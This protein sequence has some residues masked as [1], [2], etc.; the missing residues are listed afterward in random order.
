M[1]VVDGFK[2]SPRDYQKRAVEAILRNKNGIIVSPTGSGKGSI[3]V[4]AAT[5]VGK[6]TLVIV[7]RGELVRQQ[8]QR[9]LDVLE[10]IDKIDI[11]TIDGRGKTIKDITIATWQSLMSENIKRDVM[12]YGFDLLIIDEAH[13]AAG[14]VLNKFIEEHDAEYKIGLTATYLFSRYEKKLKV[15]KVLGKKIFEINIESLYSKGFL[16]R[17]T[18]IFQNTSATIGVE[19]GVGLYLKNKIERSVKYR[20]FLVNKAFKNPI[21]ASLLKSKNKHQ[22]AKYPTDEDVSLLAHIA[23]S[24]HS[25]EKLDDKQ[26]I[27]LAKK[28]IEENPERRAKILSDLKKFLNVKDRAMLLT[29]TKSFGDYLAKELSKE[30]GNIIRIKAGEKGAIS[31]LGNLDSYIAVG[32]VSLLSDGF[33][34]P[35]LEKIALC[36]PSY[37]PFV[38]ATKLVQITGRVVR[39]F[40]GK[41]PVVLVFDDTTVGFINLKKQRAYADLKRE[42]N[43]VIYMDL[44]HFV[45]KRMKDVINI[46]SNVKI[47]HIDIKKIL[48]IK[49]VGGTKEIA[50]KIQSYQNAIDKGYNP[51]KLNKKVFYVSEDET[52]Y[53]YEIK[54]KKAELVAKLDDALFLYGGFQNEEAWAYVDNDGFSHLFLKDAKGEYYDVTKTHGVK[55]KSVMAFDDKWTYTPYYGGTP[56]EVKLQTIPKEKKKKIVTFFND[57]KVSGRRSWKYSTLDPSVTDDKE[58]MRTVLVRKGYT[59]RMLDLFE[60]DI[61]TKKD[62]EVDVTR[63]LDAIDAVSFNEDFWGYKDTNNR[64]HLFREK[65]GERFIDMVEINKTKDFDKIRECATR[66]TPKEGAEEIIAFKNGEYGYKIDG[67]F[68]FFDAEDKKVL[69]ITKL[70]TKFIVKDRNDDKTEIVFADRYED[71]SIIV[72]KSWLLAHIQKK[73]TLFPEFT[74]YDENETSVGMKKEEELEDMLNSEIGLNQSS[75]YK[76]P[77]LF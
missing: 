34:L 53:V 28:G 76:Q 50:M 4:Y 67:K 9:F 43:P 45:S 29:A 32:T 62:E 44:E 47:E 57:N 8:K 42:F 23:K 46:V 40:A 54:G 19:E 7:P 72:D 24:E 59:V 21:Y 1:K 33:D 30:Y 13:N 11:G 14:N 6:K 68:T 20:Y 77:S 26:K 36:S 5:A 38:D 55:A 65:K 12:S 71:R 39:P 51:V 63:G 60:G 15:N 37:P 64:W 41:K 10:D 61:L 70:N 49:K 66:L 69:T 2:I 27:G 56:V 17:P 18:I 31:K 74:L 58:F 52:F 3:I 48:E 73:D 75:Q 16:L 25:F 35:N 22:I